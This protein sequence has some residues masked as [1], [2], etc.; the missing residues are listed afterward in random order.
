MQ[1]KEN[2]LETR[3]GRVPT[4]QQGRVVQEKSTCESVCVHR[5][6]T[7]RK[8]GPRERVMRGMLRGTAQEN[9]STCAAEQRR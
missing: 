8:A 3:V 6:D 1:K 9:G 7:E 4:R 5:G 2:R